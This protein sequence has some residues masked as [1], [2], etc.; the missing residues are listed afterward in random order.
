MC[1]D[2]EDH[3]EWYER[4]K[5]LSTER[6]HNLDLYWRDNFEN[7]VHQELHSMVQMILV[8]RGEKTLEM[9]R[10]EQIKELNRSLRLSNPF[11]RILSGVKSVFTTREKS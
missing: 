11:G 9:K 10:E 5:S 1:L 8:K 4:T 3:M 7:S 6:L 2:P